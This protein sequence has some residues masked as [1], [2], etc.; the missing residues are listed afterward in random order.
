VYVWRSSWVTLNPKTSTLH[1]KPYRV[2][3]VRVEKFLARGLAFGHGRGDVGKIG[4]DEGT[5]WGIFGI[6]KGLQGFIAG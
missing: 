2:R 6:L 5:L 1:P 3:R 4:I